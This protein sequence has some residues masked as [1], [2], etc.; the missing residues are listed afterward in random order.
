MKNALFQHLVTDVKSDKCT[1]SSCA[2][3]ARS[4]LNDVFAICVSK[5]FK[6]F[7]SYIVA[8]SVVKRCVVKYLYT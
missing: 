6:I 1:L 7:T 2:K 4:C 5:N 3:Q 8:Y